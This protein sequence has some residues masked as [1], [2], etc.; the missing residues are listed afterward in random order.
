MA[1]K[2]FVFGISRNFPRI[3]K[4]TKSKFSESSLTPYHILVLLITHGDSPLIVHHSALVT[5]PF[6]LTPHPSSLSPHH[7]PFITHP[8]SFTPYVYPITHHHSTLITCCNIFHFKQINVHFLLYVNF[9]SFSEYL[10][11]ILRKYREMNFEKILLNQ[12]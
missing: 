3:S 1:A 7:S 12:K 10:L 6:S 11:K 4:N 8:P 9:F 2:I 5:Y